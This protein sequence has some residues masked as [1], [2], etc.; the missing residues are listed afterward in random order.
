MKKTDDEDVKRWKSLV[1]EYLKD[2]KKIDDEMFE[3]F[4]GKKAQAEFL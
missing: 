4:F 3:R 2:H 1:E